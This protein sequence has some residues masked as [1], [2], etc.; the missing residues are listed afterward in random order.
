MLFVMFRLSFL[1]FSLVGLL[2]CGG[3]MGGQDDTGTT[4]DGDSD[5]DSDTDSDSDAD[6]DSDSDTDVDADSD[7]DSDTDVDS[8]SDTDADSDSDGDPTGP[9]CPPLA[10]SSGSVVN[11]SN[12]DALESAV[13]GASSGQVI[14]VAAGTYNVGDSMWLNADN[15]TL[16]GATGTAADVVIEGGDWVYIGLNVR[17]DGATIADLTI[18][19]FT[20]HAIHI[21]QDDGESVD[22]TL[23]YNTR[24]LDPTDAQIIKI[25]A[26]CNYPPIF[27]ENIEIACSEIAYSDRAPGSY[28]NGI[29]A[30]STR[31]MHIHDNVI[32]NIRGSGDN[33]GP[34]ILVW[35]ASED[36]LIERNVIVNCHRG[37][38]LG[39]PWGDCARD[40]HNFG[41]V[42]VNN[43][44]V[45]DSYAETGIEAMLAQDYLIAFNSIAHLDGSDAPAIDAYGDVTN[46]RIIGNLTN[47]WINIRGGASAEQVCNIT[48]AGAGWFEAPGLNDLHLSGGGAAAVDACDSIAEVRGDMDGEVR[49]SPTEAGADQI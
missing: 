33:I 31:G 39:N 4:P 21:A 44:V 45:N 15:V 26:H 34:A 18:Q 22:D 9:G 13:N 16:R 24:L 35:N 49:T 40:I 2:G 17:G 28:T 42:V 25:S 12:A 41:G 20:E 37:I 43:C 14:M 6:A 38:A 11:V 3:Y 30:H 1:L 47:T 46:G 8:D 7:S 29:S 48:D 5:S 19:N 23:I 36:T 32:S 27:N 10:A